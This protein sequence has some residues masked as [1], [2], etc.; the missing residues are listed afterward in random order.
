MNGFNFTDLSQV[1][2]SFAYDSENSFTWDTNLEVDY[3]IGGGSWIDIEELE[4]WTPGFTLAIITFG[5]VLDGQSSV[6]LRIQSQEWGSAFGFL[7]IDN[8]QVNAVP[9]PAHYTILLSFLA[10]AC[11]ISRRFRLSVKA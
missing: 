3:R 6:D 7:D 9:E 5:S 4:T 1:S 10:V 8:V 11:A 2:V